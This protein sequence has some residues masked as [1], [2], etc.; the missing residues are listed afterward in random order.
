MK[1]VQMKPKQSA[2]NPWDAVY[3][4][5]KWALYRSKIYLSTVTAASVQV[6]PHFTNV[7][8]I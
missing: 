2:I 7:V 3:C 5:W 4:N 8:K 1:A 6:I